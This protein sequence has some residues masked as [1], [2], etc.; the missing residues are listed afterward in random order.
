MTHASMLKTRRKNQARKKEIHRAEK[1]RKFARQA[2]DTALHAGQPHAIGTAHCALGRV[3]PREEGL[4]HLE[5]A[6]SVLR[7]TP[8]RWNLATAELALGAA[9]RRDNQRARARELLSSALDYAAR[10]GAAPIEEQARAELRLTGARP[11][12]ALRTGIE[13]LTPSEDRIAR[14]AAGGMSNKDIA[15]HLFLTVK[16]VENAPRQRLS[17]AR[18][19]LAARTARPVRGRGLTVSVISTSRR[20]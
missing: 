16:T 4:A 1:A 3:L 11:R 5:Q 14:L 12:R 18:R 17:Q 15:A 8:F 9:L 20:A 10:N 13:A 7:H 19:R 2:L 6:V